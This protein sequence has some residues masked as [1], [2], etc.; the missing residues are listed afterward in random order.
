M[1]SDEDAIIAEVEAF[2]AAWNAADPQAAA[3][4]FTE[5]GA[6]VGAFGDVQHGR[7]ALAAAYAQLF[8]GPMGGAAV[9]QERGTVRM[10][11]PGLALW[12]GGIEIQ[13][14]G[15]PLLK[16]HVVQ[17]MKQV[18]SRWLVLEAHPKFFPPRPATAPTAA[19][20]PG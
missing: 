2:T 14:P 19:N 13:P 4:F 7:A 20:Q 17:I 5:D 10:L 18:G 6:R 15:G 1:P 9:R 11:A 12:Q 8:S 3:S 16:G